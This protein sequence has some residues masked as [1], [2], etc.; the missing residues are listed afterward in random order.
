LIA[1]SSDQSGIALR[2]LPMRHLLLH[3]AMVVL[4]IGI[5]GCGTPPVAGLRD[6]FARQIAANEFVKDFQRRA[7]DLTFSGPDIRGRTARWRVHIDSAQIEPTDNPAQ[8]FKGTVKSSWYADGQRV[9][10]TES[11]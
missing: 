5:A 6:S 9:E 4:A 7:D 2:F 1:V 10:P 8:P 3:L 11:D